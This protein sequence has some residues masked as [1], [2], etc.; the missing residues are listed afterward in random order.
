MRNGRS[1]VVLSVTKAFSLLGAFQ[2]SSEAT[3][4]LGALALAAGIPKPTA[5]RLAAT[6]VCAGVLERDG[7]GYRLGMRLF[8]LGELV[9]RKRDLREAALPY[10]QDLYEATHLTVHLAVLD[11]S[12]VVYIE[13]I[14]GHRAVKVPSEVG[15]RLPAAFTG[16][17]KALLAYD[18]QAT[19]TA[20]MRR[21]D[22][23]TPYSITTPAVLRRELKQV[24]QAGV[25]YDHEE[26]RIGVACVAAPVFVAGRAI[27]GL[28]LA[29][30]SADGRVEQLGAAVRATANT[31]G[32]DLARRGFRT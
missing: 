1:N 27:A 17:G 4:S 30:S 11:G 20:M 25:A 23:R 14:R 28:S 18:E 3:L 5:H 32:R 2:A 19:R 9:A 16:V 12:D 22:A 15:G 29:G 31:L 26:S 8:E 6:L 10:M 7:E 21:V 13:R 24:R